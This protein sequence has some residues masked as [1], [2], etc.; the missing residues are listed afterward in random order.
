MPTFQGATIQ[1]AIDAGLASLG[2]ARSAVTVDVIQEGKKGLLGIG[3]KAAIVNLQVVEPDPTP[4]PPAKESRVHLPHPHLPAR[5]DGP[6]RDDKTGIA[7]VQSYLEDITAALGV[8]TVITNEKRR[9]QVWFQLATENEAFL[10]GKHGKIINAIQFL[11]QTEFNHY[12]RSKWTI[13]LNVGDYRERR[14]AAVT[15]LAERSAREVLA[16]G[17]S[18]YLDPMPSFERKAIHAALADSAY[19]Q[20]HSEGTDPRRY[21]VV[22]PRPHHNF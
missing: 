13:M 21:V 16:S 12:G 10:I 6:K 2:V 7:M 9:D 20:T 22:T 3:R 5:E 14:E 15:R 17:R 18:V 8:P 11:A 19:V 4:A 1:K